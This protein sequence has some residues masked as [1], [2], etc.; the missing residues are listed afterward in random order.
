M[1]AA[2]LLLLILEGPRAEG[3]IRYYRV[4]REAC[5]RFA[6]LHPLRVWA[7][8]TPLETRCAGLFPRGCRCS[9][10][11]AHR[12]AEQDA[13]RIALTVAPCR[14]QRTRHVWGRCPTLLEAVLSKQEEIDPE[15][16]QDR[17][18]ASGRAPVAYRKYHSDDLSRGA[19][20]S[21]LVAVLGAVKTLARF[22]LL[23]ATTLNDSGTLPATDRRLFGGTDEGCVG[24]YGRRAR[25][26]VARLR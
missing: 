13:I 18:L 22:L 2:R 19:D 6:K 14:A 5:T 16:S 12:L 26:P 21:G 8:S 9:L 24:R 15:A 1:G 4:E 7:A 10:F 3:S 17:I 23:A 20:R 25:R 11:R